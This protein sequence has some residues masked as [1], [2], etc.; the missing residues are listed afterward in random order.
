MKSGPTVLTSFKNQDIIIFIYLPVNFK[1]NHMKRIAI[2]LLLSFV[3]VTGFSQEQLKKHFEEDLTSYTEAFN[4]KK[5]NEVTQM[6]YPRVFEMMSK[7]NMQMV[8]EQ[9]DNLGVKMTTDF[10]S[11]DKISKVV[12]SGKEKY[13]KIQYYGVI[14]VKLS[15]LMSQGSSL[16]QPKFEHEFGKE[17]VK[18]H[19]TSNSF[20]IQAHRSMVAVADIKS[21]NWKYI[22]V[23]SPQARGLKKLIPAK[24]QEQLN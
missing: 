10:K 18:Y 20:T 19:E 8:L 5:W 22:D 6:M 14:S 17:N 21:N 16:M 1:T 3:I 12:E 11:I 24:V 2:L 13:C 23:N 7:E 9:M 4:N 15:G